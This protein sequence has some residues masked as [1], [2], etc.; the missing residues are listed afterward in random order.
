MKRSKPL[1]RRPMKRQ[2]AR[3]RPN[4]DPTY[5]AW[6]RPQS[7]TVCGAASTMWNP[8]HAHH[9]NEHGHGTM[10]SK[11]SDR[12]CL[13]LCH[14]CHNYVHTQGRDWLDSRVDVEARIEELNAR[15]EAEH[16]QL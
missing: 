9:V 2:A 6:I 4:A 8:G 14:I 10:G 11:T 16:D 5:L 15:W 3:R 13:P 12:R 1:K 7:C